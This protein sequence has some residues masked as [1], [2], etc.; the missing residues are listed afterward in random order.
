MDVI[1]KL[2]TITA[3]ICNHFQLQVFQRRPETGRHQEPVESKAR[4]SQHNL[5]H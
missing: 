5:P 1:Y 2:K 4:Q 3:H